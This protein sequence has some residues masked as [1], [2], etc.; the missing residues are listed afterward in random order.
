[1]DISDSFHESEIG[2]IFVDG[3]DAEEEG[4][5]RYSNGELVTYLP[6]ETATGEPNGGTRANCLL[7]RA[8]GQFRDNRCVRN[9]PT[10][11]D[12]GLCE[13]IGTQINISNILNR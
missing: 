10:G 9:D 5:W 4:V 3:S 13:N 6:W 11:A 8:D 7:V 2:R 12:F 1:M